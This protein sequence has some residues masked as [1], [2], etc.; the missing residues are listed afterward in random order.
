[1]FN[2]FDAFVFQISFYLCKQYKVPPPSFSLMWI[3]FIFILLAVLYMH[4]MNF[5]L[6]HLPS[7]SF[8]SS[9]LL[10]NSFLTCSSPTF[11]SFCLC[12]PTE[13][14]QGSLH[15]H[16]WEVIYQSKG[17][18]SSITIPLKKVTPLPEP[19]LI[20]NSPLWDWSFMSPSP[21]HDETLMVLSNLVQVLCR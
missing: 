3:N 2:A 10:L 8:I 5:N 18:L 12:T 13:F 15:E 21:F 20:G 9:P 7:P 11:M 17:N 19:S 4:I 6:F 1:M 16:R 14:N